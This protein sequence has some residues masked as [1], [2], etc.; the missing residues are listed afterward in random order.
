MSED[1]ETDK[2]EQATPFKLSRA[3]REGTVA[4]GMDLGF[5]TGLSAAL[6][7]AWI[8]G[9]QLTASI[10]QA[11]RGA[12]IGAA[13]VVDGPDAAYSAIVQLFSAVLPSLALLAGTV[14][15]IVLLFEVLQTGPVFSAKPLKPDFT[16]LSPAKGLKRLFT[17]RLLIETLKNVLKL[18]LYGAAGYF[19]IR[20]AVIDD[21]PAVIDGRTLLALMT[22]T[23][24]RLALAFVGIAAVFAVIDQLIVRREFG[25]KMRMSR[26]ELRR[27]AREREGEPRLKQKRKQLHAEFVKTNH[28]MRNVRKA[29]VLIT[30]PE[31]VAVA[32]R[33]D[34]KTMTAPIV[35][36]VGINRVAL[37]LKRLAFVYGIPVVENRI[38]A[39]ELLRRSELNKIIP[40]HCFQP[41]ANIY[42]AI[43]Q[44][45]GAEQELQNGAGHHVQGA[46]G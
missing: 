45:S 32:L 30:N 29:D 46:A 2:S 13:Q 16:R 39:R 24:F 17:L 44:A 31:H 36:S 19:V 25:K 27:E 4:R 33:Y 12:L 22:R 9:P 6:G 40:E 34:G 8:V 1:S 26:R 5:L 15:C 28:S 41:V 35:V 10:G 23:G 18:G 43:R 42:N 7:F 37:R 14:F 20:G 21:I 3:R 11:T 38:L